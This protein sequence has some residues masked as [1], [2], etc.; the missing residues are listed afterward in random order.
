MISY[1][2]CQ[3]LTIHHLYT[4]SWIHLLS[5]GRKI[6]CHLHVGHEP[7]DTEEWLHYGGEGVQ[8]IKA[9][10]VW[11]WIS[12]ELLYVAGRKVQFVEFVIILTIPTLFCTHTFHTHQIEGCQMRALC[13]IIEH[14]NRLAT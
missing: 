2:V 12:V 1:C 11:G 7:L 5:L 6:E 13:I 3:G 9:N 4:W 10:M 8:V 14:N